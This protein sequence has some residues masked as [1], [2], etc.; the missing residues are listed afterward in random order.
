M[1]QTDRMHPF[2]AALHHRPLLADGALGS[3]LFALTGRVSEQNHLYEAFNLTRPELVRQLHLEYLQAGAQCLTSNS[4]AANATYPS[5]ESIAEI[6]ATA[7]RLAHEAMDQYRQQAQCSDPLFVLGSLGPPLSAAQSP[8]TASDLYCAQIESL[9]AS[10]VDALLLE[11]FT[12]LDQVTALL[13]LLQDLD[14]PAP[15]I[16]QMALHQRDG[17]WE[18]APQTYI[19]TAAALGADVVGINCCALA[20][21]RAFLDAAQ[22]CASVRDGQVQLAVMPNGGEFRRVGHR[23]LTGVTP[24]CM[25]RFA[26]EMAHQGVRLIGGCCE[27]HLPHIHEMHNYLHGL[28]AGERI[29]PLARTPDQP[30]TAAAAKR[31]N[32]PFSRKLFDGQFAVSVELLPPRGTGGLKARLAFIAELAASGLADALDITD[33]SRGIPLM[34]PGD[35]IHLIRRRLHWERDRLELIPHC[36]SRDLNVMGLQSRLIGYWANRIHNVL[37][38]TGDPPKMAPTYPRSTAVFDLDSA[39]LIRYTHAFLNAGLDFGGQPLGSHRDPRTRFTIGTGCEPEA[40]DRQR[41]WERLARKIDA[42]ADYVMTQPT[43][44]RKALAALA[45]YRAQVPIIVGVMVLRGLE[46]ARR[47]AEVPGVVVPEAIFA[48]LAAYADPAD[49]AKAGVELATEQVRQ[50]RA[51]G[52]SGLYLMS[53]AG[54]QPVLAVLKR[55]LD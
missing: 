44:N 55:G 45:P 23:Y 47:I 26:R 7:V 39:A 22:E 1:Q 10:G 49:Q 32:G 21:A 43:F 11:T 16:V 40:L 4:F 6:N 48:K 5:A 2:L 24:E 18:Q 42:G 46:H 13:E 30:P 29:V 51:E 17:T 27:V 12:C 31:R 28:A 33:G 20:E 50:V 3:Y 36:T 34:P 19:Q 8:R 53:P 15:V 35:F 37:F 25:G 38:I 54:H 14:N 41:E 9:V 52:W